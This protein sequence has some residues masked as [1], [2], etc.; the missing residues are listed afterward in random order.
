MGFKLPL[1]AVV[2]PAISL[3]SVSVTGANQVVPAASVR[4]LIR[5]L[6]PAGAGWIRPEP[7]EHLCSVGARRTSAA[8]PV[9]GTKS[10]LHGRFVL[11]SSQY[12]TCAL[13]TSTLI[14]TLT[15]FGHAARR[16][17]GRPAASMVIALYAAS[18]SR[19]QQCPAEWRNSTILDPPSLCPAAR[20][21]KGGRYR[22]T[23]WPDGSGSAWQPGERS[24]RSSRGATPPGAP[25]STRSGSTTATSSGTQSPT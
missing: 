12:R 9:C 22:W 11:K 2:E 1:V 16:A 6:S 19:S 3:W 20:R 25:D 21:K 15:R 10:H 14:R 4:T 23:D 7:T 8:N 24:M 17:L 13:S 18:E 5:T